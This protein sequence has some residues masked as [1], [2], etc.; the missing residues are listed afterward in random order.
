MLVSSVKWN[1]KCNFVAPQQIIR[2]GY[3][4]LYSTYINNN[5]PSMPLYN[6]H[7]EGFFF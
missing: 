4:A 1:K 7:S 2:C 5:T 6:A 3:I